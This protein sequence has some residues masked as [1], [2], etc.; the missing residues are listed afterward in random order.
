MFKRRDS[1]NAQLFSFD[2]MLALVPLTIALGMSAN[3][4]SG[5]IASQQDYLFDFG[6]NRV[7]IDMASVASKNPD[8]GLAADIDATGDIGGSTIIKQKWVPPP[9]YEPPPV[10]PTPMIFIYINTT[11]WWVP[12]KRDAVSKISMVDGR[13]VLDVA[14]MSRNRNLTTVNI[15]G[16]D[17]NLLNTTK[18][19]ILSG[20]HPFK[21]AVVPIRNVTAEIDLASMS[22][23]SPYNYSMVDVDGDGEVENDEGVS[24]LPYAESGTVSENI[25]AVQ[26][27]VLSM[28]DESSSLSRY[29]SFKD[30]VYEIPVFTDSTGTGMVFVLLDNPETINKTP[31]S[32]N[33]SFDLKK[34]GLPMGVVEVTLGRKHPY[35]GAAD[36]GVLNGT[37]SVYVNTIL[38]FNGTLSSTENRSVTETFVS[39]LNPGANVVKITVRDSKPDADGMIFLTIQGSDMW[40]SQRIF[41]M[42]A[43]LNV[44]VSGGGV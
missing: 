3:A 28:F 9:M 35:T 37:I 5:I 26:I 29:N 38:V 12:F 30:D 17:V 2:L 14:T 1:R 21:I 20:K 33:T 4:M 43:Y 27:P 23:I 7:A 40:V 39:E 41:M 13:N 31:Q 8:V 34:T 24:I 36:N 19:S 42:P 25:F 22:N 15:N 16:V 44:L 6:M 32:G 10:G 18:M 11:E